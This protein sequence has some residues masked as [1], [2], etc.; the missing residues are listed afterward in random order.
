MRLLGRLHAAAEVLQVK[1]HDVIQAI[2]A[3][4]PGVQ[5]VPV[6]LHLLPAHGLAYLGPGVGQC[7]CH[8]LEGT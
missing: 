3:L 1:P 2:H 6:H 8:T 5:P 7:T 4:Q